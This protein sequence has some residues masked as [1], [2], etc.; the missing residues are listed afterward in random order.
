MKSFKISFFILVAL[1]TAACGEKTFAPVAEEIP[2][3]VPTVLSKEDVARMFAALPLGNEQ[4]QEVFSAVNASSGNGY[5]EEY[6]L[7]DLI[8]E[9]GRGV[10]GGETRASAGGVPLR[11]LIEDYAVDRIGT[12]AGLDGAA[13]V[14]EYMSVLSESGLQIY[15]PYSEQWDGKTMPLITCDPGFGAE[16]NYA[17]NGNIAV[18]ESLAKT[19]PVWVIND[20]SDSGYT[21]LEYLIRESEPA[22][23]A[24][25]STKSGLRMLTLKEFTMLR[26]YD[27]WFQGASEFC[28]KCGSVNGFSASTEAE[29]KLY[30]PSVTDFVIVVKRSKLGKPVPYD[31]VLVSD[32]TNQMENLAFLITEDDGGTSTSWKCSATVR[33]KSRSYGFDLNIPFNEKDDIV[34]RGQLNAS[35]FQSE[36]EVT[37]RFG[38]VKVKFELD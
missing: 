28:I 24:K 36:D 17:F 26:N 3:P 8:E 1:T 6:T 7:L 14:E 30:Q 15:W 35:F 4:V 11:K 22:R 27:T 9:P 33:I 34:W 37:G 31:I 20:N 16:S 25:S 12:K 5:D 2:Q 21:P 10:G 13:S 19:R 18:D 32:F 29:L 38:D 23:A